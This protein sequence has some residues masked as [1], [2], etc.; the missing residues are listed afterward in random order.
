MLSP[1]FTSLKGT[2]EIGTKRAPKPAIFVETEMKYNAVFGNII[3]YHPKNSPRASKP[4]PVATKMVLPLLFSM[5]DIM[6]SIVPYTN[7]IKEIDLIICSIEFPGMMKRGATIDLK[8]LDFGKN[9]F[10]P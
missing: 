2:W 9:D 7:R 6:V 4:R 5:Y 8:Y 10:I 3:E 1:N